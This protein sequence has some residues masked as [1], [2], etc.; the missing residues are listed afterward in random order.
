MNF[1]VGME[2]SRQARTCPTQRSRTPD[3]RPRPEGWC[4]CDQSVKTPTPM[5][6]LAGLAQRFCPERALR[7]SG[8]LEFHRHVRSEWRVARELDAPGRREVREG[9]SGSRV[10]RVVPVLPGYI[11]AARAGSRSPRASTNRDL[12][13]FEEGHDPGGTDPLHQLPVPTP[14]TLAPTIPKE[15]EA[16]DGLPEEILP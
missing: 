16:D 2:Y 15:T 9:V 1:T 3:E 6:R 10:G 12:R 11:P 13:L 14:L 4:A 7:V 8:V 5:S